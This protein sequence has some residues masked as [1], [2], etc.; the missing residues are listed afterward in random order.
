ME[1]ETNREDQQRRRR[2]SFWVALAIVWVWPLVLFLFTFHWEL[3]SIG[4]RLL[5]RS[6]WVLFAGIT[7]SW[8]VV[9]LDVRK[10]ARPR[11]L[12]P[13]L[14]ALS[15]AS[16]FLLPFGMGK[17]DWV[18]QSNHETNTSYR[19]Y[20]LAYDWDYLMDL[21]LSIFL[22]VIPL[23]LSLKALVESGPVGY[24]GPDYSPTYKDWDDSVSQD[25]GGGFMSGKSWLDDV[26]NGG[27]ISD[28]F[29]GRHGE[30]DLND[31]SRRVSEDMQQFR[32]NHRDADLSDH[33]YWDDVLD[34]DT[35]G[36]LDD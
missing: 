7:Q 26:W 19:A 21:F 31:E 17:W 32:S 8:L 11:W 18:L 24:V 4:L 34:A 2:R 16:F 10:N 36:Y 27:Q 3:P 33:Y 30:F 9:L 6:T 14:L 25:S 29:Y 5:C 1:K 23:Y 28:S 35:D 20:R 22:H 12:V 15:V 13:V